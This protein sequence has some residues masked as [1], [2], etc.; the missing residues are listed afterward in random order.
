[1]YAIDVHL[2]HTV[3]VTIIINKVQLAAPI[4]VLATL[5]LVELHLQW[6]RQYLAILELEHCLH[7]SAG[8]VLVDLET[9]CRPVEHIDEL[10]AKMR[11]RA[12]TMGRGKVAHHLVVLLLFDQLLVGQSE[13]GGAGARQRQLVLVRVGAG[14][15]CA[16]N[17]WWGA[18]ACAR[19]LQV[20]RVLR[21]LLLVVVVVQAHWRLVLAGVGH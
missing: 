3:Y 5:W 9:G 17:N 4:Q 1:M 8:L 2:A 21:V 14:A 13:A 12:G 18:V 6:Q 19:M 20:M 10:A 11:V 16:L 7:L 15:K